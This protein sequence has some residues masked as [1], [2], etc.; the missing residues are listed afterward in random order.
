[1]CTLRFLRKSAHQFRGSYL[2]P[3]AA[4]GATMA[5]AASAAAALLRCCDAL[6]LLR[7]FTNKRQKDAYH[8][9]PVAVF[10]SLAF[11]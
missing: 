9:F 3:S 2:R 6:L 5:A 7:I 10:F 11:R 4:Q 8:T 1:M